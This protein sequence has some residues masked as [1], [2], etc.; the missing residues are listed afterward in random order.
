MLVTGYYH[1]GVIELSEDLQIF[2]DGTKLKIDIL[3]DELDFNEFPYVKD[4]MEKIK[5]LRT[6]AG[7]FKESGLSDK[8][9]LMEGIRMKYFQ[10]EE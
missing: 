2:E 6:W 3:E 1:N 7:P 9:L 10:D 4:K 5:A 8:E